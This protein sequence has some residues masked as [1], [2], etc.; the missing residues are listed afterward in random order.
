MS[1]PGL[2]STGNLM[3]AS[4]VEPEP[5]ALPCPSAVNSMLHSRTWHRSTCKQTPQCSSACYPRPG[6]QQLIVYALPT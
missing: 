4:G 3:G 5:R 2:W 6:T 1:N